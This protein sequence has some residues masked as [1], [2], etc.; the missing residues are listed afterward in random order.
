[1]RILFVIISTLCLSSC[2]SS[3]W[4]GAGLVYDR[5]SL[6][7]KVND[8]QLTANASRALFHD[9]IF[10]RKD[11]SI[12]L[13]VFNRD[14]LM[15]GRVPTAALRQE[16]YER[17]QAIPGKRRFFNQL[18]ISH[19]LENPIEDGLITTQI[20]SQILADSDIDPHAFKVV[21]SEQIVYLMGDVLVDQAKKVIHFA[22]TC[23]GAKRVVTLFK[24]YNLADKPF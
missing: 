18:E 16:A 23:P 2:V 12:E 19:G 4:T 8:F 15:V 14:V 5:H 22:R 20:R 7:I 10:K 1:M 17:I 11:C 13:A 24:Y 9:K 6:Y 21:T 3:L